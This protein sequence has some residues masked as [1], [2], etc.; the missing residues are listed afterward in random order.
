MKLRTTHNSIR[1]RIRKSELRTLQEHGIIEEII[2]FPNQIIFKFALKIEHNSED[3]TAMLE[4]NYLQIIIAKA[5]AKQWIT[6]NEVG[7]E[8]N[9]DLPNEEQLHLLVEKDFPCLDRENE[10]KSDTFWELAS[11]KPDAC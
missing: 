6:T 3:L 9:I 8:A 10:D 2:R 5:K 4:D 11:D 7:I 1:I